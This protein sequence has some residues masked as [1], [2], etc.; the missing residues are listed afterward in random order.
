MS[1]RLTDD[2]I[3]SI[4]H[5]LGGLELVATSDLKTCRM[6]A[7]L[8]ELRAMKARIEAFAAEI[9]SGRVSMTSTHVATELRRR[10][11]GP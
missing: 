4:T 8:R 11:E 2:E 3:E 10:M 1:E 9:K 7:E 5:S 6:L